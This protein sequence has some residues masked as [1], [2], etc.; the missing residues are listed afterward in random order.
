MSEFVKGNW[1]TIDQETGT[2]YLVLPNDK[3][4]ICSVDLGPSVKSGSTWSIP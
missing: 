1:V 3:W 4:L 2:K